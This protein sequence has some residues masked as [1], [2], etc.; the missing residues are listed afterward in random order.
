[1]SLD[2]APSRRR[3]ARSSEQ[4]AR[5]A[6]PLGIG[7]SLLVNW[8]TRTRSSLILAF[9]QVWTRQFR[10]ID[11]RCLA[12]MR[13]S[14]ACVLLWDIHR[15]WVLADDWLAMQAYDQWPLPFGQQDP[16]LSLRVALALLGTAT[17]A[18]DRLRRVVRCLQL[19]IR[20]TLHHR[21]SRCL[22]LP[23]SAVESGVANRTALESRRAA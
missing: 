18:L 13:I 15:G 16:A 9:L 20:L 11:E 5:V 12:A 10:R 14:L 6:N 21:L 22:G 2:G 1:M 8:Y 19:S 7:E 4:K 17:L 3:T 23:A